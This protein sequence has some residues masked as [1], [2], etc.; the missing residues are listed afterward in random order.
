MAQSCDNCVQK[1]LKCPE[2]KIPCDNCVKFNAACTFRHAS[3]ARR[4]DY[5]FLQK[6]CFPD[7]RGHWLF[8]PF[9]K[10]QYDWECGSGLVSMRSYERFYFTLFYILIIVMIFRALYYLSAQVNFEIFA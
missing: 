3:L 5:R 9:K 2:D 1:G 10:L 8:R 7:Q 6:L 4:D